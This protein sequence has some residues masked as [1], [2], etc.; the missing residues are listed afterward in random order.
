MVGETR[1]TIT[2][3]VEGTPYI[4]LNVETPTLPAKAVVDENGFVLG[5]TNSDVL[6][7]IVTRSVTLSTGQE[8]LIDFY[9]TETEIWGREI[10]AEGYTFPDT[11]QRWAI[12]FE[13]TN[14]SGAGL[15]TGVANSDGLGGGI[16]FFD[17]SGLPNSAGVYAVGSYAPSLYF[18]DTTVQDRPTITIGSAVSHTTGVCAQATL[19][20]QLT[21]IQPVFPVGLLTPPFSIVQ[22]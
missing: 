7:A 2:A 17:V 21:P 22:K 13:S 11:T 12:Y 5:E 8:V 20:Q 6:P 1:A 18:M 19:T 15:L 3:Q 14:C 9:V 16:G 10:R 4:L